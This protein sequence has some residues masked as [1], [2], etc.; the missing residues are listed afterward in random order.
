MKNSSS[1]N[2]LPRAEGS[3]KAARKRRTLAWLAGLG[4]LVLVAFGLYLQLGNQ[5]SR[6]QR[7][8]MPSPTSEQTTESVGDVLAGIGKNVFKQLD[9]TQRWVE[10]GQAHVAEQRFAEAVTAFQRAY[11]L[12]G[13]QPD[14]LVDYAEALALAHGN[15]LSGEPRRLLNRALQLAPNHTKGLWL[16][17]IAAYQ[18]ED[19]EQAIAYWQR[20]LERGELVEEEGRRLEEH[21]VTARARLTMES[22]SDPASSVRLQV[23]V[24]LDPTLA[25]EVAPVNTVFVFVRAAEGPRAPLAA[26]R[27]QVKDLPFS[28]EIDD[29]TAMV[30]GLRLSNF[31]KVIV[32]ARVSRSGDVSAQSGDLQGTSGPIEVASDK[33]V[34]IIIDSRIP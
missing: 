30:P 28:L 2:A 31:S 6:Q 27:A 11:R 1:K 5:A 32:G 14:L 12:A 24:A 4:I 18:E 20:I 34:Q 9:E 25:S 13:D 26:A 33:A 16:S 29:S 8:A 17:G 10:R 7:P 23:R 21:I 19:N 3:G 15:R 22:T